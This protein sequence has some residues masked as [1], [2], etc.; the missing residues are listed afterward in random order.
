MHLALEPRERDALAG[1]VELTLFAD[2]YAGMQ[3][4]ENGLTAFALVVRR[5]GYAR[6]GSWRALVAAVAAASPRVARR[7]DG[8]REVWPRPLAVSGVPY[9]FTYREPPGGGRPDLYRTGDQLAV[10]NP[11]RRFTPRCARASRHRCAWPDSSRARSPH[12][13]AARP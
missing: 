5:E 12:R 1:S 13:S 11:R 7:L 4:I 3:H 8:A 2:G 6:L 9:G 10:A